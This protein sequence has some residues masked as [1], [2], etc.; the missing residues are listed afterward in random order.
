M[1][2]ILYRSVERVA[3]STRG[4]APGQ[5]SSEETSQRWRA[6]GG[7]AQLLS[8]KSGV[9]FPGR[10]NC[11]QRRQRLGTIAMFL[12]GC[13][14]QALIGGEAPRNLLHASSCY[15]EYNKELMFYVSRG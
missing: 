3:G 12:G 14:A 15:G 5:L 2:S 7:L 9:Q 1:L 13:I 8:R 6:V 10:S 11:T 4:L